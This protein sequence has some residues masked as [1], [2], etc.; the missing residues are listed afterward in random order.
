MSGTPPNGGST[1]PPGLDL[2]RA[3]RRFLIFRATGA[4]LLLVGLYLLAVTTILGLLSLPLLE[5]HLAGQVHLGLV[6]GVLGASVCIWMAIAPRL[7]EFEMPGPR[8]TRAEQ[9]LLF[10]LIEKIASA[11][12]QPVPPE[13]YLTNGVEAWVARRGGFLA[14][15]SRK[16]MGLGLPLL[17]ALT[18]PELRA[19]LAHEFG[20]FYGSDTLL[21]TWVHFTRASL[22]RLLDDIEHGLPRRIFSAYAGM[23]FG[24]TR[25]VSRHQEMIADAL[26]G[27]VAGSAALARALVKVTEASAAY[28]AYWATV[29]RPVLDAGFL[30]P[31][32]SGFAKFAARP[33]VQATMA[34]AQQAELRNTSPGPYD[35]HPPL[36]ERLATLGSRTRESLEAGPSAVSLLHGLPELEEALVDKVGG[37]GHRWDM[38]PVSWEDVGDAIQVP[39]W[40]RLVARCRNGLAGVTP[41]ALATIDGPAWG[42]ALARRQDDRNAPVDPE[43]VVRA[44]LALVLVSHGFRTEIQPS[45]GLVLA[46]G[47]SAVDLDQLKLPLGES[48]SPPPAW[49]AV[50]ERVGVGD[51][52]LGALPGS[53]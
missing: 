43:E 9:P 8:L 36:A 13:V 46:R 30:P 15:G 45:G 33:E 6:A 5:Y 7:D 24:W 42:G 12:R 2:P 16:V 32:A 41:R 48:S 14:I 53:A 19:V 35:S 1:V 4:L 40:R 34:T 25:T 18:V 51:V 17:Q 27:H 3:S 44:A 22:A 37:R 39:R 10:D 38:N 23:F 20:H 29:L 52:D 47:G 50:C 49:L 11:A 31:I 26:A 21:G 28:D